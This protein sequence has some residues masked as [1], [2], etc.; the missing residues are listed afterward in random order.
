MLMSDEG[1][2][3]YLARSHVLVLHRWNILAI[4]IQIHERVSQKRCKASEKSDFDW[5]GRRPLHRICIAVRTISPYQRQYGPLE[6]PRIEKLLLG[7]KD[8]RTGGGGLRM[9]HAELIPKNEGTREMMN[10]SR[11]IRAMRINGK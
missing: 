10:G 4:V 6:E 3:L 7:R 9:A 11:I 2:K 5:T 1:E 8:V